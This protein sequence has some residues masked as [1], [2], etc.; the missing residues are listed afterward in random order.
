MLFY[1]FA[2]CYHGGK[3]G[4]G[5]M[6]SLCVISYNC[7]WIYNALK[8]KS[9]IKN[10]IW[11]VKKTADYGILWMYCNVFSQFPH[12]LQGGYYNFLISESTGINALAAKI[13]HISLLISYNISLEMKLLV[14]GYVFFHTFWTSLHP[15]YRKI[16]YLEALELYVHSRWERNRKKNF[17]WCQSPSEQFGR[18]K[19]LMWYN[20]HALIHISK[21]FHLRNVD[22]VDS[23]YLL[24]LLWGLNTRKVLGRVLGTILKAQYFGSLP[25]WSRYD[26]NSETMQWFI[27]AR[28]RNVVASHPSA[29]SL[30][31][32]RDFY[33]VRS[34]TYLWWK[35]FY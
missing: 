31:L 12:V 26:W 34:L 24:G 23:L 20:T 33:I 1:S 10:T 28:R 17:K 18:R 15:K 22:N 32:W 35:C 16:Q 3:L 14:K 9:L 30:L 25:L 11:Y 13:W 5:Y 27:S 21:V 8:I 6:S 2:R 4:K 7:L 19:L 29:L